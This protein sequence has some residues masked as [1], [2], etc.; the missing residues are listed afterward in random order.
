MKDD[1]NLSRVSIDR[2]EEEI[3]KRKQRKR[4]PIGIWGI[5]TNK[6]YVGAYQGHII[7]IAKHV[8]FMEQLNIEEDGVPILYFHPL[9][10]TPITNTDISFSY[11]R[12]VA[13][14]LQDMHFV[15]DDAFIDRLNGVSLK[16]EGFV[17]CKNYEVHKAKS[18]G[19]FVIN[20]LKE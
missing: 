4:S 6:G 15:I 14:Y 8:C 11:S 17:Y 5:R 19:S 1:I 7:D 12:I 13:C 16:D 2:L 10:V 9:Y 3:E 18:K 20:F